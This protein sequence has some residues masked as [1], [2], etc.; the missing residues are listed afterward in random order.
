MNK[1]IKFFVDKILFNVVGLTNTNK[2]GCMRLFLTLKL[3]SGFKS[4]VMRHYH[5]AV[6]GWLY[7][8]MNDFSPVLAKNIHDDGIKFN[9][10]TIKPFVFSRIFPISNNQYGLKV[11]SPKAEMIVALSK[12][13]QH[14]ENLN[15]GGAILSVENVKFGEYRA[16]T[17]GKFFTLSP[18]LVKDRNGYVPAVDLDRMKSAIESNL[19]LK[20]AAIN[21]VNNDGGISH[22]CWGNAHYVKVTCAGHHFRGV[23]GSFVLKGDH[24]L[25]KTA[26]DLGVGTK[27]GLGFGC[28]EIA[29]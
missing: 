24:E 2:E 1:Q 10:Q 11:S 27:N 21:G 4:N 26:Y 13:L 6:S 12:G 9:N 5:D 18:I 3:E 23:A 16:N 17:Q 19:K 15:V 29:D 22:F 14:G 28:I 7:R 8:V 20:Y 25:L